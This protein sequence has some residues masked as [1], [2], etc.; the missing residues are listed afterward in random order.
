M[1]GVHQE[2]IKIM[3]IVKMMMMMMTWQNVEVNKDSSVAEQQKFTEFL[4]YL[5]RS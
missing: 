2:L 1:E 4:F 3:M 5:V